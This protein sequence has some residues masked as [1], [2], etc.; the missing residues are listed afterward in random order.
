MFK[1]AP[2]GSPG[3]T[4]KGSLAVVG[5]DGSLA[6]KDSCHHLNYEGSQQVIGGV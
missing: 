2:G 4:I 5:G 1:F 6:L 3:A